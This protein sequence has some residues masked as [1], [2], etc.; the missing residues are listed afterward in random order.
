[1]P[2]A[3][4]FNQILSVKPKPFYWSLGSHLLS[5]TPLMEQFF[6]HAPLLEAE[7]PRMEQFSRHAPLLEAKT[8]CMEHTISMLH[9]KSLLAAAPSDSFAVNATAGGGE[10]RLVLVDSGA[11]TL[12][13]ESKRNLTNVHAAEIEI[14][15]VNGTSTAQRV[16]TLPPMVTK[17]GHP[18]FLNYDCVISNAQDVQNRQEIPRTIVTPKHLNENGISVYFAN[19]TTVLLIADT[20]EVKGTVIHQEKFSDGLALIHLR[21]YNG[22]CKPP[23]TVLAPPQLVLTGPPPWGKA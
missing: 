18:I 8:P 7:T 10:T 17:S 1:M 19:G 4:P 21:D 11:N 13:A 22:G 20:V 2:C 3:I 23:S 9:D 16:G 14:T 5:K 6:R 12:Y 15:G